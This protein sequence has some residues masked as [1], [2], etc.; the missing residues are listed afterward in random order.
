MCTCYVIISLNANEIQAEQAFIRNKN[1][2]AEKKKNE[3][4][5]DMK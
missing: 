2:F 3:N 5:E 4:L 1:L